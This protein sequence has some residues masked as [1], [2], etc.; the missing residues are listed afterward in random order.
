[1]YHLS[2]DFYHHFVLD[3]FD[4]KISVVFI[5]TLET[6]FSGSMKASEIGNEVLWNMDHFLFCYTYLTHKNIIPH[7]RQYKKYYNKNRKL[8]QNVV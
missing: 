6:W 5:I 1:L 8:V 4:N 7:N 2:I 3:Q